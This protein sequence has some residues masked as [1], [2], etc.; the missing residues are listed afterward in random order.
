MVLRETISQ[1]FG[2]SCSSSSIS[3]VF[4]LNG[5]VK[6]NEGNSLSIKWKGNSGSRQTSKNGLMLQGD[7]WKETQ[8][9]TTA[10]EKVESWIFSRIVESIWWQVKHDNL[11]F[12]R[13]M[14]CVCI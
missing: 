10:L 7:D 14:Q 13:E 5:G 3:K 1:A 2:S 6:K 11:L 8:T 9:F 12:L 4:E